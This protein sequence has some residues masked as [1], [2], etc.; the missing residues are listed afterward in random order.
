MSYKYTVAVD[1]DG[2]CWDLLTPWI[3]TYNKISGD[4]IDPSNIEEY[5]IDVPGIHIELLKYILTTACF[6]DELK[7]YDGV[8]DS[9]RELNDDEDVD[10]IIVTATDYSVAPVKF[11]VFLNLLPFIKKDQIIIT[12]RKELIRADYV[13][14]DYENNLRGAIQWDNQAILI[15][16]NYNKSFP[17]ITYGI[18][19]CDSLK[20]AVSLILNDIKWK[21]SSG[22]SEPLGDVYKWEL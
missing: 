18:K 5:I 1:I 21:K 12:N 14:D 4:N 17:N 20:E 22:T 8:Y 3:N 2:V 9:L 15:N 10:L 16:Q 7:L 19:R 11:N 6:W 13:V